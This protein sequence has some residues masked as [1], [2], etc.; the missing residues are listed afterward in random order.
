MST[1]RLKHIDRFTDRHG[2]VRYYFRRGKGKRKVLPGRPGTEEFMLSYQ[3]A[4]AGDEITHVKK[5]RG[6]VGTFDRLVQDYFASPGY[7]RMAETTRYAYRLVIERLLR[8]E[9]IRHR[10][11]SQMSRQHVQ[12]IVGRRSAT[13]RTGGHRHLLLSRRPTSAVDLTRRRSVVDYRHK[14][15]TAG[16]HVFCGAL[17]SIPSSK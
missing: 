10:A 13:P 8:D 4:L 12:Q 2:R 7:L 1:V 17:Q 3:A 6:Q 14:G 5:K 16:L 9:K 15:G 11:A